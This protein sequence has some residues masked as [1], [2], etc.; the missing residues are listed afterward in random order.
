MP[1]GVD[2]TRD[3]QA[4]PSVD[5]FRIRLRRRQVGTHVDDAAVANQYNAY[6]QI[7]NRRVDGDDVAPL[8]E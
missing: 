1:V 6:G 4:A 3:D 7:A 8:N 5:H 2:Q